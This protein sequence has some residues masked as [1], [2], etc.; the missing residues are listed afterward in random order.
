[1]STH[2][3]IIV[4]PHIVPTTIN[5]I[6]KFMKHHYIYLNSGDNHATTLQI[7]QVMSI[8]EYLESALGVGLCAVLRLL[9]LGGSILDGLRLR[10]TQMG[11]AYA[12][13]LHS[14]YCKRSWKESDFGKV[15]WK[16]PC[17]DGGGGQLTEPSWPWTQVHRYT[18]RRRPSSRAVAASS[19]ACA[20]AASAAVS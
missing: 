9:S 4:I 14:S 17:L 20:E 8:V 1:M 13:C 7:H 19:T 12:G 6:S 10:I 15:V 2:S 16:P 3:H 5:W 11:V 18:R